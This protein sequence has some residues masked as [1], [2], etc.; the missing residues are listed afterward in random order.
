MLAEQ[1]LCPLSRRFDLTY[2]LAVYKK[3]IFV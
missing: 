1:Q 2:K 3:K